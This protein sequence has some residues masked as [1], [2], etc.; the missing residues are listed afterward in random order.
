MIK[1]TKEPWRLKADLYPR[2]NGSPSNQKNY[3]HD[4]DT[5]TF[6]SVNKPKLVNKQLSC[7][8]NNKYL[9]SSEDIAKQM[10]VFIILKKA[11]SGSRSMRVVLVYKRAG[12]IPM[13]YNIVNWMLSTPKYW[14]QLWPLMRRS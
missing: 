9:L 1:D 3:R 14:L 7:K 6:A 10:F 12:Q 5:E 13:P 8:T 4:H 2:N 11:S